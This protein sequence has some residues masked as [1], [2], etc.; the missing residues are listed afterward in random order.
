MPLIWLPVHERYQRGR[1]ERNSIALLSCRTGGTD[2]PST[3]WLGHYAHSEK[4]RTSGLWNANHVDEH[5]DSAFLDELE[6]LIDLV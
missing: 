4:V 6:H 3:D 2:R 5:H 1:I